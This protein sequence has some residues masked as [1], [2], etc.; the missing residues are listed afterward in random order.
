MNYI[1]AV[2]QIWNDCE[3]EIEYE[4]EQIRDEI[5]TE[6]QTYNNYK[7]VIEQKAWEMEI[8]IDECSQEK[9]EYDWRAYR[10]GPAKMQ[11]WIATYIAGKYEF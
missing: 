4:V 3:D 11:E 6:E 7:Q 5:D 9:G 2:C 8:D 1:D 10:R